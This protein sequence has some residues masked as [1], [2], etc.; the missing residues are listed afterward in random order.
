MAG[1]L[2]EIFMYYEFVCIIS[3]AQQEAVRIACEC[4]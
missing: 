3:P 4:T 2:V 1:F